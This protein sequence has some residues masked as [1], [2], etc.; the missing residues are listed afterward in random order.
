MDKIITPS[1]TA[2]LNGG[3]SYYV[4]HALAQLPPIG[5][6]LVTSVA[7]SE[8][9]AVEEIRAKGIDVDVLPSRATV[10]FE[11]KYGHNF[12]NRK[13]R[14]LAK[15]DP[16][17]LDK[18]KD[19]EAKFVHLGSLLADD[20]PLEVAQ[21]FAGKCK[22]SVDA[23]GFLRFVDGQNVH[24]CDWE[25]KLKWLELVDIL[26]VNEHEIESLTG[27]K[28]LKKAAIQLNSWG[29]KEVVITLGSYGSVVYADGKY[30]EI[31][32]FEPLIL[33]D[34]TGCGDTYMTGYLYRRAQGAD[35]REAGLFAS[36]MSTLKLEHVGP[37]N[38]TEEAV[39]AL[40]KKNISE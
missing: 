4:A 28:D 6:K 9:G 26:K 38:G 25:G 2:Y 7:D 24:S 20:F 19:V 22:L 14:V 32:P 39:M 12:N 29:V 40:I 1:K 18:V 34:A 11:N 37:F 17:T 33:T 30:V 8:L 36:A 27:Y 10:Y 3:T 13:Q 5:F 15:A 35:Y 31:P 23:Q 16:F 21:H